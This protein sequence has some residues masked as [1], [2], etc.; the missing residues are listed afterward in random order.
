MKQ[1]VTAEKVPCNE[2]GTTN[3]SSDL[4][5]LFFVLCDEEKC[6]RQFSPSEV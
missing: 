4:E 5:S 1:N 2:Q 3:T 6:I